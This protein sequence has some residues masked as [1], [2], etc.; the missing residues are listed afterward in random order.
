MWFYIVAIV[1]TLI[2]QLSKI[3]IRMHVD[4][5][6]SVFLGRWEITHYENS[7]M[8]FSLFQG[9]A[10]LFGLIAVLFVIGVL[11]YRRI[12]AWH[13]RFPDMIAGFLVGGAIGNGIDRLVF[14]QVT[15]FI[16]SRSG[17][18]ILNLADY[19][20]NIGM[21]LLVIYMAV[22]FVK[23]RVCHAH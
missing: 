4:I 3:W 1:V 15:D 12:G 8:A 16:V 9:Y 6:D 22:R 23:K 13:G 21:I 2:D 10:W 11:I 19:A 17:K 5:G 7:G 14:G 18:G 20:I